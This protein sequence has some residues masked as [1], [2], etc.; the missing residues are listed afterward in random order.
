MAVH[1][2][3]K[4]ADLF[5]GVGVA[6]SHPGATNAQALASVGRSCSRE[7]ERGLVF[8]NLIETDQIYGHRKD[9]ARLRRGAAR[10]RRARSR[11]GCRACASGDLL[12]VTADHGVDP[13][14]AGT[15]HTRE[16]APLLARD[17]RD[18]RARTRRQRGGERVRGRAPRRPAGRRRRDGAALARRRDAR[19]SCRGRSSS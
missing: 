12:I 1:G 11:A 19:A 8:V 4:I 5:A 9:V 18:G 2:V 17:R 3:G 15:D 14:H 7:L 6:H 10:D 16:Y 13:S